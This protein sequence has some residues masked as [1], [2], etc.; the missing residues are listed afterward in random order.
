MVALPHPPSQLFF[1]PVF[2]TSCKKGLW[3]E[4]CHPVRFRTLRLLKLRPIE[5]WPASADVLSTA[6]QGHHR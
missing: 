4:G 6:F 5:S 3:W 2:A 1:G